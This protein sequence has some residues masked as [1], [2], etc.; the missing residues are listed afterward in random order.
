M[1]KPILKF[2]HATFRLDN[3]I[4][5]SSHVSSATMGMGKQ[6]AHLL[7]L[8]WSWNQSLYWGRSTFWR[9]R[10]TRLGMYTCQHNY[11]SAIDKYGTWFHCVKV[12]DSVSHLLKVTAI[13]T[14]PRPPREAL[15]RLDSAVARV[16]AL[17]WDFFNAITTR[18]LQ[19][20]YKNLT[21]QTRDV[22]AAANQAPSGGKGRLHCTSLLFH[23]GE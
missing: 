11:V 6:S 4:L 19:T 7:F 9:M 16:V 23:S 22:N 5:K 18:G 17:I 8:R 3:C 21:H 13:F 15:R 14:T 1:H 12:L 20:L 10:P 2:R